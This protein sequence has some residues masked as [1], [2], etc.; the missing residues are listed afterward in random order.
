[1]QLEDVSHDD[2]E[3]WLDHLTVSTSAKITYLGH[4]RAFYRWAA[5]YE[6]L[7]RDP[8]ARIVAPKL[9][10]RQPRPVP[11]EDFRLALRTARGDVYPMMLLSGYLGLRSG[12]IAAIRREEVIRDPAGAYLVVHGKGGRERT[13]PVPGALLAEV[14][15]W[16]VGRGPMFLTP[17]GLP[18]RS[19]TVTDAVTGHFRTLGMP[20][21]N[22]QLRHRAATRLL[23]LTRDLRL[24]QHF[25]G[26]AN[27]GTT[28]GYTQVA[29]THAHGEV[30]RL[31]AELDRDLGR[32][33]ESEPPPGPPPTAVA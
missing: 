1:M 24:V 31:A 21:V 8:A 30:A 13:L 15:P 9:R 7:E 4:I 23:Q 14:E 3:R 10:P 29:D 28:S 26:H 6:H 12:E 25:L 33:R 17:S 5:T 18:A 20:Y 19:Q 11:A 32:S 27:P 2:I 16:L 22:H